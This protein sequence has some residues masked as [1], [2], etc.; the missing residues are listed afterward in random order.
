LKTVSDE[1]EVDDIQHEIG[2]CFGTL[3]ADKLLKRSK[4]SEKK[5]PNGKRIKYAT[6]ETEL[7]E[8]SYILI[9][10]ILDKEFLKSIGEEVDAQIPLVPSNMNHHIFESTVHRFGIVEGKI[11]NRFGVLIP[12]CPM[13]SGFV[14][15]LKESMGWLQKKFIDY[16]ILHT[17]AVENSNYED[18]F[19]GDAD[20]SRVTDKPRG[21]RWPVS[22]YFALEDTTNLYI[23]HNPE[24]GERG[25]A[26]NPSKVM[27][28]P[29]GSI[30]L[31][32]SV[33]FRHALYPWKEGEP[34]P[35]RRLNIM[36]YGERLLA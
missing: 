15:G 11:A 18:H 4:S 29:A 28:I 19:H 35:P 21:E 24:R 20:E 13:I 22:L 16:N 23:K 12:G 34:K 2:F 10:N 31:F 3:L 9:P 7:K 33:F 25:R 8:R 26:P 32:D 14:D 6:W 1:G 30:L 17:T 5:N 27:H 36:V